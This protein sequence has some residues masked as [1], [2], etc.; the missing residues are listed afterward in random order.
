MITQSGAEYSYFL[1][2]FGPMPAFLFCWVSTFLLKP[3][4]LAIISLSFAKYTVEPFIVGCEPP[5]LVVKLVCAATIGNTVCA[6]VHALL[7]LLYL[8]CME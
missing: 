5:D 3:S 2:A 7:H 4:Q 6:L 8:A 1:E